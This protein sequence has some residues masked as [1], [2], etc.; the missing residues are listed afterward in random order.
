MAGGKSR[1]RRR[2]ARWR[3]IIR[4][5][6]RSGLS[7]REFCSRG[8]LTET[9]FYFWRRE[10]RRRRVEDS[11]RWAEQEQRRPRKRPVG[12]RPVGRAAFVPVT[13]AQDVVAHAHGRLEIELSGGRRVHVAA[14]VDRQA[15][16]DVLAVLEGAGTAGRGAEGRPC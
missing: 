8:K 10:L 14:P 13:V 16:A 11:T 4:E 6:G 12:A 2:E 1:D 7:V 3:R 15:L 9:A 5:Q